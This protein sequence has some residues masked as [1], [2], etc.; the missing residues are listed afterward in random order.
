LANLATQKVEGA[1]PL[2]NKTQ[3]PNKRNRQK[4]KTIFTT[5]MSQENWKKG[6]LKQ[7]GK[8]DREIGKKRGEKQG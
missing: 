7:K 3:E 2:K 1:E 6:R 8:G 5:Q 4:Q